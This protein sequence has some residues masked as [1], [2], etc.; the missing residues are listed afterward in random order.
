PPAPSTQ[1]FVVV[2]NSDQNAIYKG[3][4]I[5][6]SPGGDRLYATDF[7]NAK[8]DV[9]DDHFKP[10][11]LPAGAFV[12][13]GVPNGYGPFGIREIG[14]TIFV[15]YARQDEDAEDDVAGVGLGFVDAFDPNGRLLFR[16][17]TREHLNAPWGL[18]MAP[19]GFGKFGGAL[20]VGNFG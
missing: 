20:L 14:G 12:D 1:A 10:V 4:A 9:F 2:D 16:V 3:L 11:T 13:D 18:A 7:H 6:G 5:S 19:P 8:V 17:A 15:T